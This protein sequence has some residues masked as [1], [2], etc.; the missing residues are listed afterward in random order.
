MAVLY[1]RAEGLSRGVGVSLKTSFL[2]ASATCNILLVLLMLRTCLADKKLVFR[3]F[4][5][6]GKEWIFVVV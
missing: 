4:E 2:S 5:L 3:D 1:R 6:G